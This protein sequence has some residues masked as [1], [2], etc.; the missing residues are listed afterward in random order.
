MRTRPA[1]LPTDREAILAFLAGRGS[2]L[3]ESKH[4]FV[5]LDDNRP[6]RG[7]VAEEGDAVRGYL[8]LAPAEAGTWGMELVADPPATEVLV[9]AAVREGRQLGLRRLRWWVYPPSGD[10]PESHGFR[11]EREL[12]VMGRAL[13]APDPPPPA[14]VT[15][16][17]FRPGLDEVE[18]LEVNNAAFAGHPENGDLDLA[19]LRRRMQL[20]WYD[21]EGVRMAREGDR[22]RGF[23]WTK[24]H[25]GEEGEIYIIGV[26]PDFQGRGLGPALVGEGMRH[27]TAVGCRRVFLYTEGDNHPAVGMYRDLGFEV[28]RVNRSYLLE[29]TG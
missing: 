13:P 17:G 12:L 28:E 24:V 4:S 20:D 21:P 14:G 19:E 1:Q 3:S 15:F 5:A 18:W 8:G 6:G 16:D 2:G 23:C 9:E 29:L 11:P 10:R 26:H 22:L 25:P 27:L 7:V